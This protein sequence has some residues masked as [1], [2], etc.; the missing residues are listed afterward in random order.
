M[1]KNILHILLADDDKDDHFFFEE[2]L[3]ELSIATSFSTAGNG[4]ELIRLLSS[5]QSKLPDVIF[6]D[7]N[8]P[9]K[10]GSECLSE[11]KHNEKLKHIPIIIYSTALYD[12]IVN[13]LY[14]NGAHYY[15]KKCEFTLLSKGIKKVLDLLAENPNQPSRDKFILLCS[16]MPASQ[17]YF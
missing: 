8:M 17:I 13:L 12:G 4:E 7:L 15:L 9:R 6:L 10:N 16:E 2:S 14:E 1:D 3:K 11:I 5:D